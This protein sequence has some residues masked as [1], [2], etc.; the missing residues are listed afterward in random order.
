MAAVSEQDSSLANQCLA[1]CQALN[2]HGK[3]FRFSLT[4]GDNFSFSLDARGGKVTGSKSK[5]KRTS[6]S[7]ARR[8]ARRRNEFL[9]KKNIPAPASKED[10]ADLDTTNRQSVAE[11]VR[12][13]C[14]HCD[15]IFKTRNGLKIHIGKSHKEPLNSPEVLRE[16]PTQLL[17]SVSPLKENR[18]EEPCPNCG[19][20]MSSAHL[21]EDEPEVEDETKKE[22][23]E[24]DET[25]CDCTNP[26]CCACHHKNSC[27]CANWKP[28]RSTRHCT[29]TFFKARP[30]GLKAPTC[31]SL[32]Y[33]E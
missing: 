1:L 11:Q 3:D 13:P 30:G 25:I 9:A 2:A 4:I 33:P 10:H 18:R 28:E 31:G 22:D 23:T 21:C 24:N 29:C 16:N 26:V 14:D 8:N 20:N 17:L 12:Y 15:S 19:C 32:K 5:M 6:P 7:T 27:R